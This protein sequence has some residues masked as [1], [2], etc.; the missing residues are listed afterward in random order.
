MSEFRIDEVCPIRLPNFFQQSL[1]SRLGN[2]V[3]RGDLRSTPVAIDF[4]APSAEH[5]KVRRT[6]LGREVLEQTFE[7]LRIHA[8]LEPPP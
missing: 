1:Q 8:R 2:A 5:L 4:H 3:E 7:R 6:R